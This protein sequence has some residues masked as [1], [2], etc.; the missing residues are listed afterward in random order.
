MNAMKRILVISAVSMGMAWPL[1]SSAQSMTE[2]NK[3]GMAGA[4]M[5]TD[6]EVKK[7]DAAA[8]KVTI[9]HGDIKHLEMPGMTMV[10]SAKDKG[11]LSKIK[12]GDK[13][14]FMVVNES[15]K[16]VVTDIQPAQ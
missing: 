3:A 16:L 2:H 11:L 14:K 7:I 4:P 13:V 8:G 12:P 6:G 9:K 1:L 10:F 5:M 15:G